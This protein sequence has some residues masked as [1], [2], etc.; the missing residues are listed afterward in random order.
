MVMNG[1]FGHTSPALGS[2]FDQMAQGG[3]RFAH[4]AKN[5][6]EARDVYAVH[7]RLLA[8]QTH[9]SN[10]LNPNFSEIG[11]GVARTSPSGVRVS[12]FFIAGR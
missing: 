2:A 3:V 4:A 8:S 11:V 9:R 10:I 12:Q 7:L 6:G 5:L 1:Y